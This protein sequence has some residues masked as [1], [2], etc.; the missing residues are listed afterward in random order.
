MALGRT[1]AVMFA[2]LAA[3]LACPAGALA[4]GGNYVI[5]G[6]TP[7]EQQQVRQAL[8]VSS[9]NWSVVSAQV[10]ISIGPDQA[11]ESVPGQISLSANLL[12]SGAFSW[13]VVQ[14]EYAHQV[15]FF[16]FND[17]TRANLTSLLGARDWCH[18]VVGLK[19]EQ[20]GCE[21]FASTLAWSYWPVPENCMKPT[22]S[23]GESA[24]MRPSAFR[25]LM[26]SLLRQ[27]ESLRR[28]TR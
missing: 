4:I 6:G 11:P 2:A 17:A 23:N 13:G 26:A 1:P 27:P 16:L 15:D 24:A 25:S 20:H 9:F 21:R 8:A 14:H 7:Y 3:A 19:H 10:T 22:T 12:D 18:E 5:S 28:F